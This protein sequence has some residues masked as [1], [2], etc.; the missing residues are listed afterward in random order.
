M[1]GWRWA[2]KAK[3]RWALSFNDG[4]APATVDFWEYGY[5]NKQGEMVIKA[6]FE[7]AKP[8]SEGVAAVKLHGK[9]GYINAPE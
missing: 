9:W 7:N 8:F 1:R 4:L 3:F 6:E 2:I 5:I